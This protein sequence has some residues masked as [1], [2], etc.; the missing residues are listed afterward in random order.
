LGLSGLSG[1]PRLLA[2]GRSLSFAS[3][4]LSCRASPKPLYSST[5]VLLCR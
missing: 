3:L 4:G 1:L 2:Y 5:K